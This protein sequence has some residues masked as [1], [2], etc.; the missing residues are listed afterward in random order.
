MPNRRKFMQ[1]LAGLVAGVV[2]FQRC[3]NRPANSNIP[4]GEEWRKKREISV[5]ASDNYFL[6]PEMEAEAN[7]AINKYRKGQFTIRLLNRKGEALQGYSMHF[8]Q[9]NH[10]FDWGFS[11]AQTLCSEDP[12]VEK[13]TKYIKKLFNCT[14][15]KCYWDERWHQPIEHEEGSRILNRFISE[16]QWG[17]VNGLK[18]KGHPLVWTVRKAIPSWMDG[19]SYEEQMEKLEFHVRD[20]IRVGG[21]S[22]TMWDL[23]NE[24][25]WEP[26]LRH[27]PDREWPHLE[28]IDEIL[29]YLEP[30]VHWAKDENP[31]AVYSLNDYGLV[32]TYA[33]G[34]TSGQQRRRYVDL[35]TEMRKRGCAPD[36][37]GTQCH[38]AGWYSAREFNNML[39]DLYRAGL[40]MQ[41][42]EF[43]A[44]LKDYPFENA[45]GP[46]EKVSAL[47]EN[48]KMIYTLA[49]AHPGVNHFTYWGSREWFEED[50]NPT[51]LYWA[52][53][54][55]IKN[56][57][58]TE[59]NAITNADGEVKVN[60]FYGEYDV[61]VKDKMGNSHPLSLSLAKKN[62]RLNVYL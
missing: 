30:A 51:S 50:G 55:L 18:V 58:M 36:E 48:V 40:P 6:T 42:T 32:K 38:V 35:I 43:W 31:K 47:I 57:W 26:S 2:I 53:H 54:N 14:T 29:T 37:I 1:H 59:T 15:A 9:N 7:A 21:G 62:N 46:E 27:L 16:I 33:P 11:S 22:V 24:M 17:L 39:N 13:K 25:L 5:N 8:H 41:V 3:R 44:H 12:L 56:N 45:A 49:F 34:V 10:H 60:G 4:A 23:C 20:L 28:T 19:Y 52:V 61:V